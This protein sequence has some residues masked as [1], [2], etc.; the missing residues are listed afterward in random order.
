MDI[1]N[2]IEVAK[3]N[4]KR[5]ENSKTIKETQ[6][7]AAEKQRDDVVAKMA[8][9]GVTPD[10]IAEEIAGLETAIQEGLTKIEGLIPKVV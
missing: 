8:Q 10:V 3:I 4:L 1:K 6:K 5:A 2:R 9:E 7:A